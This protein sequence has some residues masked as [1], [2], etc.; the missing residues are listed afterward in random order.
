MSSDVAKRINFHLEPT[1]NRK[2]TAKAKDWKIF[3]TIDNLSK[4]QASK[5]EIHI[6]KMKSKIY[7]ENLLKYPEFIQKLKLKYS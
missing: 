3:L 2:F 4:E 1:E 5:I 7:I 6:K